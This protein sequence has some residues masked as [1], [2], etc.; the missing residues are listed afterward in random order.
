M[1]QSILSTFAAS[2]LIIVVSSCGEYPCVDTE[3]SYAV[4]GFQD[5]EAETFIL[6]RYLKNTPTLIDSTI[7][8]EANPVRFSRQGDTL[9]MVTYSSDAFLESDVDYEI[10]FPNI[11][12]TFKV[13]DIVQEQSYAKKKGLFGNTKEQCVNTISSCKINGQQ[14]NNIIGGVIYL[15][16]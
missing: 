5:N 7:F 16:R 3:L 1:K 4:V 6:K 2:L 15:N 10:A 9:R 11:S 13:S 8:D 12:K 14:I